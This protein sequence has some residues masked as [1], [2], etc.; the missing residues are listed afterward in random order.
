MYQPEIIQQNQTHHPGLSVEACQQSG[1]GDL[2]AYK[3]KKDA[4]KL[5]DHRNTIEAVLLES[6]ASS[7]KIGIPWIPPVASVRARKVQFDVG[8][9]CQYIR[10]ALSPVPTTSLESYL[11]DLEPVALGEC[12]ADNLNIGLESKVE[13]FSFSVVLVV[14]AF[15][16]SLMGVEVFLSNS[17]L[18][19][20][21]ASF[22]ALIAGLMGYSLSTDMSRAASFRVYL[23]KEILRRKGI[24]KDDP[25]SRNIISMPN[26]PA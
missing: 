6:E 9:L 15:I 16:T 22:L 2:S 23:E 26:S 8:G 13:R 17:S 5:E 20:L 3:A 10:E 11:E 18:S 25:A 19:L 12:Q 14:L 24:D 1:M 4:T 7:F 21:T